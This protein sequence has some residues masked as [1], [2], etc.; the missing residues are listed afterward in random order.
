MGIAAVDEQKKNN[1]DLWWQKLLCQQLLKLSMFKLIIF[2]SFITLK[3]FHPTTF[4]FVIII[5][6]FYFAI[7]ALSIDISS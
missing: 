5:N 7:R 3:N 6:Y 1:L 2:N 4:I